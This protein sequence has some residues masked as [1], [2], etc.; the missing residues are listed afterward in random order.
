MWKNLSLRARLFLPLGVLFLIALL[1]GSSALEVFS[2]A[3]FVFENEPEAEAAQVVAKALNDSLQASAN[4]RQTLGA[5]AASLGKSAVIQF[6]PADANERPPTMRT[7]SAGVPKWFIGLL[8][9]PDLGAVHPLSIDGRH[10]GD[11]LFLPDISADI[12]EKWVGFL[13]IV[14]SATILMSL[15][16]GFAYFTAGA[17]LHPLLEL[18]NGLSRMRSGHYADEIPVSGPPEIRRSCLEANELARMLG[19]LSDDNRK[20]L[21]QIVSLQ[22]DE[23]QRLARELHD[24][25]GPLL[26]AIRANSTVLLETVPLENAEMQ[27]P[28]QIMLQTVEALQLANRRILEGLHPLYLDELGLDRSLQSLFKNIRSQAPDMEITSHIDPGL[29][30]VDSLFSQT[31]YRV[32]QES[33]TNVL[34]HAEAKSID[35]GAEIRDGEIVVE[36]I[37]DGV[38]L[39][40]DMSFGRGLT[41]MRE[42]VRALSGSFELYRKDGHTIVRCRLPLPA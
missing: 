36:V 42:R 6:R 9:I 8:T 27:L 34:R 20:L 13:A 35:I 30:D 25:L 40:P 17:V 14:L 12:F 29:N 31:V 5:F 1:I 19:R 3:Q 22:D 21:H 24:E 33:M 23:R 7:A 10:A 4:P 39:A 32:L 2:P 28:L 16:A 11:I 26:F 37:D 15:S 41:G 38:G 18:G